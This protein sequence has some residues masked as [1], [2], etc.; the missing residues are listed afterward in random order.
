MK[1]WIAILFTFG[2]LVSCIVI[3][4]VIRFNITF[5]MALGTSVWVAIDSKKIQI[6]RYKSGVAHSPVVLFIACALLWVIGFPWYLTVRHK[7][8]T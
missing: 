8:L 7:I 5:Y 4:G 3:S 1:T 2:L 6:M